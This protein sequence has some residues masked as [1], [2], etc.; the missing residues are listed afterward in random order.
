MVAV[1]FGFHI[2]R[3]ATPPPPLKFPDE[4][5]CNS[6]FSRITSDHIGV[7]R[8]V[9][10]LK[11]EYWYC[12][13]FLY[14]LTKDRTIKNVDAFDFAVLKMYSYNLY[15]G[16]S[17]EGKCESTPDGVQLIFLRFI[18][19]LHYSEL[20]M[21]FQFWC[22]ISPKN[23]AKKTFIVRLGRMDGRMDRRSKVSFD[24]PQIKIG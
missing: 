5:K 8:V 16:L 15:L 22:G 20:K 2:Y 11:D 10:Y 4:Y 14:I 12:N 6:I 23:L 13:I 21:E 1:N 3:G 19:L 18:V 9:L 17:S 7:T 24:F